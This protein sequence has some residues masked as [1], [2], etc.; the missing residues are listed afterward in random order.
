MLDRLQDL[1]GTPESDSSLSHA[2]TTFQAAA[3]SLAVA[4]QNGLEQREFVRTGADLASLLRRS[5]AM[6]QDL[7]READQRIGD[8]VNE[9][10]GLLTSIADLNERSSATA[11]LRKVPPISR[12]RGIGP[13]I[14][15][16]S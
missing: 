6:V 14:T 10:N 1:F 9:I 4:P 8:A 13:W 11:R 2:L 16:P 15:C 5:S 12:I 3:N 7:R